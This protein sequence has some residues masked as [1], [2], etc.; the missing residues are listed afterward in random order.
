MEKQ[1]KKVLVGFAHSFWGWNWLLLYLYKHSL[2]FHHS[3]IFTNYTAKKLSLYNAMD[4][5]H[6]KSNSA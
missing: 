2:M 6:S 5:D 3:P 4:C 1:V